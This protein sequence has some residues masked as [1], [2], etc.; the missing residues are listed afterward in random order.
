MLLCL[1]S[2]LVHAE[3]WCCQ[4][5]KICSL[6]QRRFFLLLHKTPV[7]WRMRAF[8]PFLR[9]VAGCMQFQ[10][11]FLFFWKLT[12]TVTSSQLYLFW[13]FHR[14]W[15]WYNMNFTYAIYYACM[16]H[17]SSKSQNS[18]ELI[19]YKNIIQLNTI[20]KPTEEGRAESKS[21]H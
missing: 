2:K 9:I 4:S 7:E 17:T 1:Y 16:L 11:L 6:L 19:L 5:A 20:D 15:E 8:L 18:E 14:K 21:P 12:S 13:N 10:F 3:C